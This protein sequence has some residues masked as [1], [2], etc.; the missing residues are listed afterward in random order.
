[1]RKN[2]IVTLI[3]S[4]TGLLSLTSCD[5]KGGEPND[6]DAVAR[7]SVVDEKGNPQGGIP[8]L[9]Y[10]E[11]GYEKF[12][13]DRNSEP[14]GF[15]ITLPNGQVDCR[16]SYQEWFTAGNRLVSFVIRE[17]ADENNYRIWTVRKTIGASQH[18]RIEFEIDRSGTPIGPSEPTGTPVDMYDEENGRTTLF[19]DIV[20]LDAEHRLSGNNRYSF[21]DAGA[22]AGLDDMG[23]FRIDKPVGTIAIQPGN[24]YFVCKN[25]ALM[26]FPS[27][28]WGLAITS[29]LARI[30]VSEWISKEDKIVGARLRYV[31]DKPE[32]GGLPEW[33]TVYE[34][35]ISGDRTVTIPL[36]DSS[37]EDAECAPRGNAPLR[38]SYAKDHATAQIVDPE[39]AADKEYLFFIRSGSRYTEAKIRIVN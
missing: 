8:I 26:E 2:I 30:H 16:L 28:K 13:N 3:A 39:I 4:L 34:A 19:G 15:A 31:I 20:T 23:G 9:I 14:Q 29:E 27:G 5:K 18:V 24:G 32:T 25:I 7:V 17:E 6:K 33:D 35:N 21:V 12:Q 38:F 36:P 1:M 22:G 37:D 11:A 10:D